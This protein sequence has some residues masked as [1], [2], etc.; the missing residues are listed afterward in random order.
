[1]ASGLREDTLGS[2][3]DFQAI[4]DESAGAGESVFGWTHASIDGGAVGAVRSHLMA[5]PRLIVGQ[6]LPE[7]SDGRETMLKYGALL[8]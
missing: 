6:I 2:L 8:R 7:D 3:P 4:W 1:M 5:D